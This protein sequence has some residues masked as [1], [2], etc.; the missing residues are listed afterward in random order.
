MR[1]NLSE[2]DVHHAQE[3]RERVA[4]GGV[5]EV[6]PRA[7]PPTTP[8]E[9]TGAV[10]Y[11]Q[12]R[13]NDPVRGEAGIK[14]GGHGYRAPVSPPLRARRAPSALHRW[15]VVRPAPDASARGT[16]APSRHLPKPNGPL[17]QR[18]PSVP[19]RHY[20][21]R[22][23]GVDADSWRGGRRGCAASLVLQEAR[24]TPRRGPTLHAAGQHSRRHPG[25]QPFSPLCR[26][27]HGRRGAPEYPG[28]QPSRLTRLVPTDT[29]DSLI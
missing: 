3:Q 7:R 20:E 9:C 15:V 1:W 28:I 21:R 10:E 4:L 29:Y 17:R 23:N 12:S 16:G 26:R 13:M 24:R 8:A 18:V 14:P 5:D 6:A 22:S 11:R 19:S 2:I 25:P 27:R